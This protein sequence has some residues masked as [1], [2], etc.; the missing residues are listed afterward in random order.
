MVRTIVN[1]ALYTAF[2]I[3]DNNVCSSET[4]VLTIQNSS[5]EQDVVACDS[6]EWNGTTYSESGVY[7]YNTTN[8]AGCDS[9]AFLNLT[10]NESTS[11]ITHI[12][13]CDSFEWNGETYSESS[14]YTYNTNTVIWL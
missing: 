14:V 10:I 8:L 13:A 9:V 11:S 5:S 7:S 12:T 2:Y 6:F 3:D 1:R 4:L